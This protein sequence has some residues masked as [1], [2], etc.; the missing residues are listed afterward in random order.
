MV[1][2]QAPRAEGIAS[3][4]G[5]VW[6]IYEAASANGHCVYTRGGGR[7]PGM[8]YYQ[9]HLSA[10][11]LFTSQ[12]PADAPDAPRYQVRS[13]HGRPETVRSALRYASDILCG[14]DVD[15]LATSG[16]RPRCWA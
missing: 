1:E 7:G 16:Q 13:E 14:A 4:Q 12:P 8:S 9:P 2:V 11:Q 10:I 5:D 15:H 6:R 3:M